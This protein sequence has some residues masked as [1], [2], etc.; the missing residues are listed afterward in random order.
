M[1]DQGAVNKDRSPLL[2]IMGE[3]QCDLDK[4][5]DFGPF[6]AWG[7]V[8][9]HDCSTGAVMI[10]SIRVP[11]PGNDEP[12][13]RRVVGG[14]QVHDVRKPHKHRRNR[15]LMR[16]NLPTSSIRKSE[17]AMS[18]RILSHWIFVT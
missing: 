2:R 12:M 13:G 14:P 6:V 10:H 9:D 5:R 15:W 1:F 7:V 16:C 8:P 17:L 3:R 18:V 4:L 11:N